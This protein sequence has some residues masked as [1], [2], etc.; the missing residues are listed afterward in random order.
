MLEKGWRNCAKCR[1]SFKK[2][3]EMIDQRQTEE[4]TKVWCSDYRYS[5]P[6]NDLKAEYDGCVRVADSQLPDY[7]CPIP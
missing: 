1:E 3:L 5:Y 4:L 2:E 7:P 6:C